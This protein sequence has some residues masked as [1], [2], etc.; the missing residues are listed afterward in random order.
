MNSAISFSV[1]NN[2]EPV[3]GLLLLAATFDEDVHELSQKKR[4]Y[5]ITADSGVA[6]TGLETVAVADNEIEEGETG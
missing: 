6:A 4:F 3:D 5:V 2:F 1:L